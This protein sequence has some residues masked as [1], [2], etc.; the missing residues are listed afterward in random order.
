MRKSEYIE[1]FGEEA[2]QLK[3]E[4]AK[5]YR[6]E[7]QEMYKNIYSKY[8]SKHKEERKKK[9]SEYYN[10]HI[11][12]RKEYKKAYTEEYLK[13]QKGRASNLLCGYRRDDINSNYGKCTLTKEWVIEHIFNSKCIYCGETDWLKLGC[14]RIDNNLPHTPENCV[15][16]CYKC[17]CERN[18]KKMSFEEFI[19][20]K[21][22]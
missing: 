10:E 16:A 3:I 4:K 22:G 8:Y 1:K 14:D 7:H 17:N 21:K 20:Y 11:E 9:S 18:N 13:T 15:C 2:W 5:Q 6:K 12:H 19:K